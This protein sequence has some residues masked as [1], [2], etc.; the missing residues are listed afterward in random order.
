MHVHSLHCYPAQYNLAVF[1][2]S[3]VVPDLL[4]R[5]LPGTKIR[6]CP[7]RREDQWYAAKLSQPHGVWNVSS[8]MFHARL[9]PADEREIWFL[10]GTYGPTHASYLRALTTNKPLKL[11]AKGRPRPAKVYS[12]NQAA[13]ATFKYRPAASSQKEALG[14]GRIL[15]REVKEC[16]RHSGVYGNELADTEAKTRRG[17]RRGESG[18]QQ[19]LWVDVLAREKRK[20]IVKECW[21]RKALANYK[22]LVLGPY[23]D[24]G[25][26]SLSRKGAAALMA[27]RTVGIH[28]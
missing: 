25:I 3:T 16:P 22:C 23:P 21:E 19:W 27:H 4:V 13:A 17:Q 2:F 7:R 1:S 9:V 14:V 26:K 18:R 8:L 15:N 28:K 24:E 5:M 11:T 6:G 10:S 20:Q 12:D